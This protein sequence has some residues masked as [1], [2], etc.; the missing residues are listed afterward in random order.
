MRTITEFIAAFAAQGIRYQAESDGA[1]LTSCPTCEK[2]DRDTKAKIFADGNHSCPRNTG[3]E[4]IEHRREML[5]D[6]NLS[7]S[8][9]PSAF[10]SETIL[11]GTLTLEVEPHM[12]GK[13]K[14]TARNCTSVL[15]LH[16]FALVDSSARAKFVKGLNLTLDE[17]AETSR[18]LIDLADRFYKVSEVVVDEDSEPEVIP[19]LFKELADGRRAELTRQGFACYDPATKATTYETRL[20]DSDGSVYVPFAD[21]VT[22]DHLLLAGGYAEYNTDRELLAEVESFLRSQVDISE[23]DLKLVSTYVLLTYLVDR[24][25]TI[26]YLRAV[27]DT[28]S[29]KTRLISAVGSLCRMPC[30]TVSITAASLFRVI[31]KYAPTMVI[32]EAN[33]EK[34]SDDATALMQ[35]SLSGYKNGNSVLRTEKNRHGEL[36][37]KSYKTFGAKIYAGIKIS[38]SPAFENCCHKIVMQETKRSDIELIVSDEDEL[39]AET[40]R[41]RLTLWRL[42]NFDMDVKAKIKSA[43]QELKKKPISKRLVEISLPLFA[44]IEDKDTRD[45]FIASLQ[46]RTTTAASE[47]SDTTDG[48]IIEIIWNLIYEKKFNNENSDEFEII[49]REY[50]KSMVTSIEGKP[51]ERLRVGVIAEKFNE[52]VLEKYH[53]DEAFIGNRLQKLG[54]KRDRISRRASGDFY[55]KRAV[56]YE[57]SVL[58]N[59]FENYNLQ[60]F[61]TKVVVTVVSETTPVDTTINLTTTSGDSGEGCRQDKPLSENEL[62]RVTTVTTTK[63]EKT[64]K[65]EKTAFFEETSGTKISNLVALDTETE[66]FDRKLGITPRN[67]KMIGLSLSYDG[68]KADYS[69]DKDS[70]NFLMPDTEQTVI[71]HNAK[72]D[73]GVLRRAGLPVPEK[74]EDTL[75]A[76]HLLDENNAH[77]LKPLSKKHLGINDPLTFDE[78]DKMRLLDPE[79]FAEY[80]RN[81]ARYTFR[82]WEKFRTEI[83]KQELTEVYEMEKQLLPVVMRMEERGMKLDIKSLAVI[84]KEVKAESARLKTEIF[85][86]AGMEFELNKPLSVGAVLF[87]KL[88][89]K[90]PKKTATGKRSVDSESLKEIAHPLAVKILAYRSIDKL[91]NTFIKVLPK[92]ADGN[93]RIHPEFKPLGAATGRFSCADPNVQQIPGKSE[94]GKAVRRAFICEDGNKLIVA[95]FSQMELRVLAHY[96]QDETLLKAYCT[97]G[98]ETDLHTITAQKLF[99]KTDVSK[100]ER[101]I[102]KMMNFGISYGITDVGLYGRLS[103]IGITTTPEECKRYINDYFKTYKGVDKFLKKVKT[104]IQQR[105]YVKNF[106]GRRRRL[107]G[108]NAREIRQAQ[109]FIIQ[110]TSADLVKRAMVALDSK[111]PE[112]A[113]LI[114]MIHDELII[115]C[116]IDHAEA[117]LS[118]VV[119]VMQDTPEG[120]TVPMPVDAKIVDCWADAK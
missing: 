69:T 34:G 80:A 91:A 94:L 53:K 24:M 75:I 13:Q 44:L 93:G 86:F 3:A 26:P 113:Q 7:P 64:E 8:V 112:G 9:K 107:K 40:L 97:T 117:V 119:E 43:Q 2:E 65:T 27:G 56:V 85:D 115:E 106:F 46:T 17:A 101:G 33:F 98:E 111:L 16:I 102:A 57:A 28:G 68:Q 114:S 49:F 54:L 58:K 100:D 55:Q 90:C 118:I 109:N 84:E 23:R 78:A 19:V 14:V 10:M 39:R 116:R 88:G 47:K 50:D 87:D 59:V 38:D 76:A 35:I 108:F 110:A 92:F 41:N 25:K 63:S 70:W 51:D 4:G 104:I 82:L 62:S 6:W 52:N 18:A 29:G 79:V 42:R 105:G 21:D 1:L 73:F 81:D 95:D 89:L 32:D 60:F 31:D 30:F 71:F 96:S 5:D 15:N 99:N 45:D 72:F 36:T 20:E 11:G 120:F 66:V 48:Q 37:P 103:A 61:P 74:F 12:R 67:A 22:R 83:D 77:G